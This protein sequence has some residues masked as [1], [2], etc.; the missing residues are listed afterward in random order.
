MDRRTFLSLGANAAALSLARPPLLAA[1]SPPKGELTAFTLYEAAA[2]VRSRAISPMEL[3]QACLAR[4]ERYDTR[5]NAFIT[6]AR[7]LALA[8]AREAEQEIVRGRWR[9]PLH[10]I[11]IALKDNIDTAGIRTTAASDLFRDRIPTDDAEVVR[12]LTQAGAVMLGKLNMYEFAMRPEGAWGST[13]NPW[14]LEY[15]T[16]GSSSGSAAAVAAEFCFGALGTDSGGSVRIPAYC[17]GVVGLKPTYGLVSNRGV[18]PL[19]TSYDHVGPLAKSTLD[20]ALLLQAMAGYD[21]IWAGFAQGKP[22]DYAAAL[23]ST[24]KSFGLGVPRAGCFEKLDSEVEQLVEAA[25][26]TMRTIGMIRSESVLVPRY[27]DIGKAVG[28]AEICMSLAP[29]ILKAAK[30]HQPTLQNDALVKSVREMCSSHDHGNDGYARG[31]QALRDTRRR[32]AEIFPD[33]VALLVLPTWK[34]LPRTIAER[35][36]TWPSEEFVAAQQSN[37]E[38][39][40]VLGLPAISLPCGYAK[41]GL[42]VGIQIVGRP[43]AESQVLAFAQAYEQATQWHS[44]RPEV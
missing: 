10:G 7:E 43:F 29:L 25:L 31:L 23:R 22:P 32:A 21:P 24:V 35:I 18:I 38:P 3:T 34:H 36:S 15:E 42:P 28:A 12:R 2:L 40:N 39:F 19:A 11:P 13:H 9:G 14:K 27:L 33:G 5:I 37:V 17:C 41:N 26:D 8:Q 16:G 6:V 30:R 4:I 1:Q 20:A 44:R